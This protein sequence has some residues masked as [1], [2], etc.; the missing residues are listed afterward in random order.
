MIPAQKTD[1]GRIAI[2]WLNGDRGFSVRWNG[3]LR[4][5]RECLGR[6]AAEVTEVNEMLSKVGV[7]WSP[8]FNR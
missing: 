2:L 1:L 4:V 8:N 5:G 6:I 3:V 7:V